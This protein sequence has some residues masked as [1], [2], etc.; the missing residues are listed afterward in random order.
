ML[1]YKRAICTKSNY[2]YVR[3]IYVLRLNPKFSLSFQE[4]KERIKK[5]ENIE[6]RCIYIVS[7]VYH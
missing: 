1:N 4:V 6:E 3:M 5:V 2:N 7:Q